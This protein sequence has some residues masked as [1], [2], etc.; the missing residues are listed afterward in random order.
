ME[1][2]TTVYKN[3]KYSVIVHRVPDHEARQIMDHAGDYNYELPMAFTEGGP[4]HCSWYEAVNLET[5]V[6]ELMEPSLPR[7]LA[8]VDYA[9]SQLLTSPWK[10]EIEFV[11][12]LAEE[13]SA[14]KEGI[15]NIASDN[16]T[17]QAPMFPIN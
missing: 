14:A 8:F 7:V 13:A 11:N 17:G 10:K 1:N 6:V 3:S 4:Q 12:K 9:E 2:K 16:G 15:E 5:G